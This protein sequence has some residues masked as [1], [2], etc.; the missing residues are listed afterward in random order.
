MNFLLN[1]RQEPAARE[2]GAGFAGSQRSDRQRLHKTRLQ[3]LVA[4]LLFAATGAGAMDRFEA[5]A[6]I[7]SGNCDTCIG[8]DG[9]V[10]RYQIQPE[11]WRQYTKLPLS[12]ASNPV[13]AKNVA[14]AIMNDRLS[15]YCFLPNPR[16][17]EHVIY[18][19]GTWYLLWH[20]P[21]ATGLWHSRR[22]TARELERSDRFENL[23]SR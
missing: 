11:V 2:A 7:E 21:G 4:V 1:Q 3:F 5:L 13:T 10:S 18:G 16:K 19:D 9:E 6:Q 15:K 12:A 17:G 8:R 14:E 20:R 23:C 22:P